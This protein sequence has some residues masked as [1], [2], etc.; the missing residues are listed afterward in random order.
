MNF[1]VVNLKGLGFI[2]CSFCHLIKRLLTML[3][4]QIIKKI[5]QLWIPIHPI[6]KTDLKLSDTLQMVEVM[7][8]IYI[9]KG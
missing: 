7:E 4:L 9:L 2:V 3:S 5:K 6:L 8:K 1:Q